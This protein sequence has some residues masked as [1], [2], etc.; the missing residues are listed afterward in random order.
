[1]KMSELERAVLVVIKLKGNDL[2]DLPADFWHAALA[3][4]ARGLVKFCRG[5]WEVTPLAKEDFAAAGPEAM[6]AA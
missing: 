5:I 3:L 1:M 6:Q 2:P 4:R